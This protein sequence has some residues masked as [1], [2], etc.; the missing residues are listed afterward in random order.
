MIV[1]RVRN[2]TDGRITGD[3]KFLLGKSKQEEPTFNFNFSSAPTRKQLVK[4]L[5][6]KYTDWKPETWLGVIDELCR[7]VQDL[8]TG[9]EDWSII[10]PTISGVKHPGYYIEPVVM[11]GV[12]NVIHGEKGS[13]KTTLALTMLGLIAV[14]V[15]DSE[16]GLIATKQANVAMID[17]EGNKELTDYTVSRLVEG[18]TVPYFD[19]PY[20]HSTVPLAENMEK[21]GNFIDET[22]PDV[23]LLDSLGRLAGSERYDSSGKVGA[24]RFFE[25]LDKFHLT[26]L[27][28][29]QESKNEEGKKSIYGSVFYRYYSRNIFA[30]KNSKDQLSKDEGT[31]ALIHEDANY[32]GLYPPMGFRLTYTDTTIKIV[33]TEANMSQFMDR[34]SLT[35]DLLDYLTK[36]AR[37]V[38]AIAD[39]LG[40]TDNRVRI[41]LSQLKRRNKVTNLGSGVWGVI[42][43]RQ[44]TF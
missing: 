30:L 11:K 42:N 5:S 7:Q 10:Q 24:D 36:G 41:M 40:I 16:T 44:E 14:G 26:S 22:K 31:V 18:M 17:S 6:E 33:H 4:N 32:S 3:V 29:G 25:S 12:P 20:F 21:V 27:I 39:E 35:K 2:H 38:K 15:D 1:Q 37:P 19:L 8:S 34:V 23:L 28:I 13:N 9:G 43:E